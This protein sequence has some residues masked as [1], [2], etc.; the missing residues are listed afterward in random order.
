MIKKENKFLNRM[1]DSDNQD[2]KRKPQKTTEEEIRNLKQT[3]ENLYNVLAVEIWALAKT[4][5]E[6]QPGFWSSFMKNRDVAMKKYIQEVIKNKP[7]D[8]N[9]YPFLR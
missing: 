5:D 9:K 4:M 1:D 7:A 3:D 2:K 8:D 6:F